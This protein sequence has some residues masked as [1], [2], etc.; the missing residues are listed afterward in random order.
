M[1]TV[2]I[3]EVQGEQLEF[4][5]LHIEIHEDG[6]DVIKDIMTYKTCCLMRTHHLTI[7]QLVSTGFG[8][9]CNMVG[10][11]A[12]LGELQAIVGSPFESLE[13]DL[14]RSVVARRH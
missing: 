1:L 7:R 9:M 10:L 8:R 14:K 11:S 12:S 2:K 5:I 4:A 6:Q 13:T 3:T